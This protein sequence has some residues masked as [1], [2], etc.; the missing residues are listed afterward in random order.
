[1]SDEIKN[2][3]DYDK[4]VLSTVQGVVDE[5]AR[6]VDRG[7]DPEDALRDHLNS[8]VENNTLYWH[9][10]RAII[11]YSDH[12]T[13]AEDALGEGNWIGDAQTVSGVL[14]RIARFA[15]RDDLQERIA[16]GDFVPGG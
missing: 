14:Q 1:M 5:A 16:H 12:I 6:D 4:W 11:R 13:A 9:E 8:A 2:Q 3:R 15:W 10:F 7:E